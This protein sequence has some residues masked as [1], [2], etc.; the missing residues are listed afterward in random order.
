M[1][2]HLLFQV[3]N[4]EAFNTRVSLGEM[5]EAVGD[6]CANCMMMN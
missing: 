2:F 4:S 6:N 1:L 5:E 3:H